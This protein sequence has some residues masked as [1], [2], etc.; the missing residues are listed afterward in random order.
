MKIF[1]S[2]DMEGISGLTY[3][4]EKEERISSFMTEELLSVI[5]GIL[6]VDEDAEILVSDS[7]SY[8]RN[9][10][11]K[12]LPRNVK[13]ISGF[14]REFYMV[15]GIDE[16]FDTGM[17]IGYH[18]PA[19]VKDAEMDHTYS[20]SSLYEVRINNMVVGEA[21]ING[22]LLGEYSVPVVLI[23][24]D[25]KL[26]EFSK[27]HFK[28]TQFVVTKR[29]LG[30][31]AVELFPIEEV[32]R[33]LKEKAKLAIMSRDHVKPFLF[34]KPIRI[35]IKFLD[36]LKAELANLIPSSRRVDGRTVLFE[37]NSIRD[38]YKFLMAS[39]LIASYSKN[40]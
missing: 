32:H 21:E 28:E 6:E 36:T 24:G 26:K 23:S 22:A 7:H 38:V 12:R 29:S 4:K 37:S 9:I 1:I 2:I 25:D 14:P 16:S 13:L 20:S 40:L 17:F 19:G 10:D 33:E 27:T 34:E 3:W 39:A 35:E 11:I 31:F 8:G 5:E 18:A 30:R 15:Q